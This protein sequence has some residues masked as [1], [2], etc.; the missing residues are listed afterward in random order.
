[1]TDET[2]PVQADIMSFYRP[3]FTGRDSYDDPEKK[4][5]LDREL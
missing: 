2:E 1:M 3:P 4:D 5:T